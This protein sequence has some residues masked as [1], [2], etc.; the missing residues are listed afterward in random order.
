MAWSEQKEKNE[1]QQKQLTMSEIYQE[2]LLCVHGSLSL[3]ISTC[4]AFACSYKLFFQ[5]SFERSKNRLQTW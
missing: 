4:I 1:K 3:F 5:S 2:R